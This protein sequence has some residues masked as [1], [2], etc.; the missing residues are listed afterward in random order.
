MKPSQRHYS[1]A[2]YFAIEE[3]SDVKHEFHGGEIFAM[4]GA[5]VEHNL[6]AGNLL[7]AL[8]P[9][10]RRSRCNV[11]G[12][13]LRIGTPSGLYTYP[14]LSIVCGKVELS[15]DVPDTATNPRM[16]TKILSD[17][18]GEYDRGDKFELYKTIPTMREYVLIDQERVLVD[19]F[20]R[21]TQG[22]SHVRMSSLGARLRLSSPKVEVPLR[23]I[24]RGVFP[25]A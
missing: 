20:T 19:H 17:A 21:G 24:Y 10:L 2:D 6:I 18:T 23:E 13:D 15:S 5:S 7:A 25:R 12:S 14:D 8:K 9:A 11:F 3:M 22:W 16:I 1:L 4:A